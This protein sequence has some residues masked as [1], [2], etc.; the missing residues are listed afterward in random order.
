MDI[1]NGPNNIWASTSIWW[2]FCYP[3]KNELSYERCIPFYI[4]PL[5]LNSLSASFLKLLWIIQKYSDVWSMKYNS[6]AAITWETFEN[7]FPFKRLLRFVNRKL[8][9]GGGGNSVDGLYNQTI[10]SLKYPSSCRPCD[11]RELI[12]KV[13]TPF[14]HFPAFLSFNAFNRHIKWRYPT[15][16]VSPAFQH[17]H[18]S[19]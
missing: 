19:K 16:T 17:R 13:R 3:N 6:T 15:F 12:Y 10:D 4:F 14:G 5:Q 8:S 2:R 7:A 18:S 11:K 1:C 9:G